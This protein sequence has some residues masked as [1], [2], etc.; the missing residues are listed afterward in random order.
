[1]PN[2]LSTSITTG[3]GSPI[4]MLNSDHLRYFRSDGAKLHSANSNSMSLLRLIYN[5]VQRCNMDKKITSKVASWKEIV[6]WL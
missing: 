4:R 2:S 6:M 3:Q 1:M 5:M